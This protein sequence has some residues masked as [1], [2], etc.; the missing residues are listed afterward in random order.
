MA[1]V[2][3]GFTARDANSGEE[4]PAAE[5]ASLS[6]GEADLLNGQQA[7]VVEDVAMN[8]CEF[9][10]LYS[11]EKR[12]NEGLRTEDSSLTNIQA[13]SRELFAFRQNGFS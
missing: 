12:T 9:L 3:E 11:S 13:S 8:Q 7:I 4:P 5:E 6:G 2:G 10:A 1:F